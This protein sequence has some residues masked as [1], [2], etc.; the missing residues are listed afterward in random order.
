MRYRFRHPPWRHGWTVISP[1][2]RFWW[3]FHGTEVALLSR[4]AAKF[5]HAGVASPWIV[6]TWLWR[7]R[8]EN[9]AIVR[10]C[11]QFRDFCELCA[12][13][14]VLGRIRLKGGWTSFGRYFATFSTFELPTTVDRKALVDCFERVCG[15]IENAGRFESSTS[16]QD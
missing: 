14:E 12:T 15:R 8:R 7:P 9:A 5:G 6:R 1:Y 2:A 4:T 13:Q 3:L 16:A 10:T 11:E